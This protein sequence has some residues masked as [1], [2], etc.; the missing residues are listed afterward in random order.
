MS[1][2]EIRWSI[3]RLPV[4]QENLEAACLV[5]KAGAAQAVVSDANKVTAYQLSFRV[6]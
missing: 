6:K 2:T 5:R 4:F 1:E 3:S